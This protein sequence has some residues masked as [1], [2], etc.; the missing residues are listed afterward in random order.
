MRLTL[1]LGVASTTYVVPDLASLLQRADV[2]LYRAKE[3]GRN[4]TASV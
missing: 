3:A 2:A 1:S 4:R